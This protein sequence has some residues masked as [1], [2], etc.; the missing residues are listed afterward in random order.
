M[1]SKVKIK[2]GREGFWFFG[3]GVCC[4]LKH[5]DET[6]S[7]ASASLAME[8]SYSK[9]WKMLRDSETGLGC[10]LVERKSGGKGGGKAVLTDKAH[11]L[12]DL[13]ESLEKDVEEY[14]G[15]RLKAL[16]ADFD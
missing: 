2:L 12:I 5:I 9:A 8:L 6:G 16:E 13:F 15:E 3:P 7:V 11:R 1:D 10:T 4:L 14:T